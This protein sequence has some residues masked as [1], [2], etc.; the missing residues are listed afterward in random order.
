MDTRAQLGRWGE[1]LAVQHLQAAGYEVL[2]RNW[3]CR[4]G[5]LD[6]VAREPGVLVFVEVK[7]RSG[8]GFGTPAEAVGRVKAGRLRRLA[9]RWLEVHRPA[10]RFDLRFDVVAIVRHRGAAPEVLHLRGAF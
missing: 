10:G 8:T 1:D 9:C 6:V 2:D 3:R 7:A 4:E 5:E